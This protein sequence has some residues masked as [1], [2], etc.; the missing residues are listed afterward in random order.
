MSSSSSRSPIA[1]PAKRPAGEEGSVSVVSWAHSSVELAAGRTSLCTASLFQARAHSSSNRQPVL[2]LPK[3]QT[4]H[5]ATNKRSLRKTFLPPITLSQSSASGYHPQFLH[6]LSGSHSRALIGHICFLVRMWTETGSCQKLRFYPCWDV[7][8]YEQSFWLF[9]KRRVYLHSM[10]YLTRR[11]RLLRLV[12]LECV[13]YYA[14]CD[15]LE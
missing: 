6:K 1:A 2:R 15:Q 4:D 14:C 8:L 11:K 9:T 7:F 3:E 13:F 5:V 12:S 10:K